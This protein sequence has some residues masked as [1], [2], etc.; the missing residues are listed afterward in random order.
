MISVCILTKNSASTLKKTLDQTLSFPEVLILDNGSK[1][2]TCSIAATYPN[3]KIFKSPFLGFGP[4]R[5]KI[6]SLANN[7]WIL[8]LDS[9]EILSPELLKELKQIHLKPDHIYSICRHNF[10]NNKHIKGCGWHPDR[11]IRL[12]NRLS[13]NYC[14]SLVHESVV[15]KNS[16]VIKLKHPIW[17]TPYQTTFDFLSKMQ[18]YSTLFAEQNKNKKKS[19]FAI[20]LKHAA[21]AFLKSYFLKKGFVDGKEGFFISFYNANTAFYKYIKLKEYNEK[22]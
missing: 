21:F 17:H 8:A 6:A 1:D 18:H 16:I 11:V 12:Y 2:E 13:T 4:M 7:D 3:V 14:D 9:D 20:A 15:K 22:I 5:N 19:S 10:Y